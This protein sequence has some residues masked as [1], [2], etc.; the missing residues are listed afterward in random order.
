[1]VMSALLPKD[2][3][4]LGWTSVQLDFANSA[5]NNLF[6]TRKEGAEHA[7]VDS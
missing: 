3:V 5:S 7:F 2:G 4:T 1:M 6:T